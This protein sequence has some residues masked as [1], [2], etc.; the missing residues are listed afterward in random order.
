M[1]L[2]GADRAVLAVWEP[3]TEEN[4]FTRNLS[5]NIWPQLSQLAKPLWTDP[6]LR[7]GIGECKLMCTEG[8][9]WELIVERFLEILTCEEKAINQK[10]PVVSKAIWGTLLRDMVE[11]VWAFLRVQIT[12]WTEL[13][14]ENLTICVNIT[15]SSLTVS[16]LNFYEMEDRIVFFKMNSLSCCCC[17]L[18]VSGGVSSCIV[19]LVSG[20]KKLFFL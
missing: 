10:P 11:H 17:V 7:S 9:G 14:M 13:N 3:I 6:G 15:Y 5:G 2:E 18:F 20:F 4:E 8:G 12:C 16:Q 1:N 19:K